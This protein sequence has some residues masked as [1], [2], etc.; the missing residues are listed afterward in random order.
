MPADGNGKL[1]PD[2]LTVERFGIL[3]DQDRV[4]TF[5]DGR[6]GE[7]PHRLSGIDASVEKMAGG[8]SA[9]HR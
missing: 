4:G 9:Y 5:R 2:P 7:D 6:A 8:G 3:L 1:R